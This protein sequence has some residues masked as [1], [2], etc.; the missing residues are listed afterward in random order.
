MREFRGA[1][2][3]TCESVCAPAAP[4][5]AWVSRALQAPLIALS[6]LLIGCNGAPTYDCDAPYDA[7]LVNIS[8]DE[9]EKRIRK[10]CSDHPEGIIAALFVEETSLEEIQAPCLCAITGALVVED[11]PE[12]RSLKGLSHVKSLEGTISI[13]NNPSLETL[14]GLP[15]QVIFPPDEDISLSIRGNHSLTDLVGLPSFDSAPGYLTIAGNDTLASLEGLPTSLTRVLGLRIFANDQLGDISAFPGALEVVEKELTL[16][17]SVTQNNAQALPRTL[18]EVGDLQLGGFDSFVGM[19]EG[20]QALGGDMTIIGNPNLPDFMGLERI[21]SVEGRVWIARNSELRDLS[22]LSEDLVVGESLTIDANDS[23]Q[24]LSGLPE[25]MQIG[26]DPDTGESLRIADNPGL[27]GLAGLPASVVSLPGSVLISENPNLADLGGLFDNLLSVGGGLRIAHN[28][29]MTSLDGPGET[30]TLG[31]DL[32]GTSLLVEG[33][34]SLLSLKGLPASMTSVPGHISIVDN[35]ALQ[36]LSGLDSVEAV[37]GDL[38]VGRR[39]AQH[40][41]DPCNWHATPAGNASMQSLS[42]LGS[43]R[44]VGGTLAIACNPSLAEIGSLGALSSIGSHLL[45]LSNS[46]LSSLSDLGGTGGVLTS[47]GG[48]YQVIC[49]PL[50]DFEETVDVR[51]EVLEDITVFISLSC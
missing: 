6:T 22:G 33:N 4:R 5:D 21:A 14:E 15:A 46:E 31:A 39:F 44:S 1:A 10:I 9:P 24:D 45:S 20:L 50:L 11:N 47:I 25:G 16:R 8:G 36:D 48:S 13:S 41:S 12:L 51:A 29:G 2:F 17:L 49:S 37:G 40:L 35:D 32:F 26:V 42:G 38:L 43:L 34:P 28:D 3:T 7:K 19:P 23:L 18:R 27:V 30:L